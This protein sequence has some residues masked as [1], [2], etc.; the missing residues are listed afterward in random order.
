MSSSPTFHSRFLR[1]LSLAAVLAFGFAAGQ[2]LA[3]GEKP[4]IIFFLV[5][6]MGWQDTSVP[7]YRVRGKDVP[8]F[9][10]KRYRTPNME[11][12][13]AQGVKFTH[14]YA[15]PLCTPTRVSLL[16]GMNAARHRVTNW[17][18]GL[19]DSPDG[20]LPGISLPEWNI[21]GLQPRGTKPSGQSKHALTEEPFNY[22][23]KRPYA[24]ADGL[25]ALLKRQGYT[26]IHCGKAHFGTRDTPGANPKVFGFDYNIAGMEIGHPADYRGSKHYGSGSHH[27]R[28]LDENNYYENDVFLTEALTLEALKRLDAIRHDPKESGKPFY[29]YMAHY[30]IHSP[31]NPDKRFIDHYPNPRDGKPWSNTERNYCALIE[32]MDKSLGDIMDY[33]K[34][35]RLDKNTVILFM[36]DNGGLSLSTTSRMGDKWSNFPLSLGKGSLYEGGIREPMLAYWPGVTKPGSVNDSPVIAEDFFPTI[37]EIAGGRAE[38]AIQTIDGQ[39][40]VKAMQGKKINVDRPLLFHMPNIWGKKKG[41]NGPDY[42][43]GSALVQGDWKLIYDHVTQNFSLFHLSEDISEQ[44][45]LAARHPDR[46]RAMAHTMTQLLKQRDAQMPFFNDGDRKGQPIPWPADALPTK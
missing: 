30:A 34:K 43:P 42:G 16:S 26:T 29:L 25:P 15:T 33:L 10:N 37:L 3:K 36:A 9:L 44:Q 38:N 7:F 11:K 4:N 45:N 14:A 18:K 31:I 23:M 8:T 2:A 6:D 21:N 24:V 35:N 32:G 28:G 13:A 12:L 22:A 41:G 39:S 17:V 20:E 5:D 40:F 46:V 19:D 27:V 1:R